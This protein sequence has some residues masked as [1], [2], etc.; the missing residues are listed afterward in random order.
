M[1]RRNLDSSAFLRPGFRLGVRGQGSGPL[2]PPLPPCP[3]S[4]LIFDSAV[5]FFQG[6]LP[7]YRSD[8]DELLV[9]ETSVPFFHPK[10][11]PHLFSELF[12]VFCVV[13][14]LGVGVVLWRPAPVHSV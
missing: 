13:L 10:L 2:L 6:L 7:R 12:V 8:S 14:C 9:V 11:F 4:H 3:N 5:L 1:N